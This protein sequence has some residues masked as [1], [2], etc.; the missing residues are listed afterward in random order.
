MNKVLFFDIDGTL[1]NPFMGINKIPQSVLKEMRRLKDEGNYL[2]IASGRPKAF[3]PDDLLN[4]GFSGFILCNGAYIEINDKAIYKQP[5]DYHKLVELTCLLEK[6]HCEYFLETATY[7]YLDKRFKE[8]DK[9]FQSFHIDQSKLKYDFDLNE[10][11]KRTLKLEL[12]TMNNYG[13]L[14]E[15]FIKDDFAYDC[16]GTQDAYEIYSKKDS[17][18]TAIQKV[19]DYFNI[20]LENS[21][22]FGD[23]FNDIE[24]IQ[25]AGHGIAMGNA[26]QQLKDVADEV[27]E[28]INQDGL[29]KYLKTL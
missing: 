13:Y 27:C 5:L 14:I 3:I 21:Y 29:A 25:Y 28:S 9:T 11:L 12:H 7:V 24:M 6:Y 20:S 2:F 22:A 4:V 19:L 1:I 18:A 15:N 17:K 23:G 8:L 26:C 10:Q 16:H